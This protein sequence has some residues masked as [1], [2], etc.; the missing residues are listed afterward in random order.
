VR[1]KTNPNIMS[2]LRHCSTKPKQE[3]QTGI[4]YRIPCLD[5]DANYIGE[6]A[7]T[8]SER[9]KEHRHLVK[10]GRDNTLSLLVHH[11]LDYNH[12]P[13]W[14]NVETIMT[15][16][17]NKRHRLF[18]EGLY[19]AKYKNVINKFTPTPNVYLAVTNLT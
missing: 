11:C 7:R 9:L 10:C 16:V 15:G 12:S 2:R 14:E 5:C 6:T 4:I 1:F 18:L 17:H 3:H 13:D 8:L 19:S